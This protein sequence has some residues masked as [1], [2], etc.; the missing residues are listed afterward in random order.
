MEKFITKDHLDG[1]A[2]VADGQILKLTISEPANTDGRLERVVVVAQTS[3][4][5]HWFFL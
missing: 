5:P 1:S 2:V 4:L 3:R